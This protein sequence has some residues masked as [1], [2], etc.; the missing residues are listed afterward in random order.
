MTHR[1]TARKRGTRIMERRRSFAR[2]SIDNQLA[3][4]ILGLAIAEIPEELKTRSMTRKL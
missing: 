1:L 3:S 4:M 2:G